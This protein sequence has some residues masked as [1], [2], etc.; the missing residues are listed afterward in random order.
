[1]RFIGWNLAFATWLLVSAF[2]LPQTTLSATITWVTAV[3]VGT[4]ALA[5]PGKP[6]ARFVISALALMLGGAAL[7]T[8]AMPTI[9][10][11]NNALAAAALFA[12]S[13][14]RPVHRRAG[15]RA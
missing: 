4:V 13:M 15:A 3:L 14:V 11:M 5:A 7:L 12:L 9:A 1:M 8:P 6:D 2:A 10:C